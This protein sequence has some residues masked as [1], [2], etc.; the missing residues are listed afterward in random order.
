MINLYRLGLRFE[1]IILSKFM[2]IWSENKYFC[3]KY[4]KMNEKRNASRTQ[5]ALHFGENLF[6]E[7]SKIVSPVQTYKRSQ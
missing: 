3:K 6:L 4:K 5:I 2:L 7:S 1:R